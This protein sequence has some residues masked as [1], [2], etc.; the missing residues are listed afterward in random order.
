MVGKTYGV[1][2]VGI[3]SVARTHALAINELSN[4]KLIGG[5]CRTEQ[6]GRDFAREFGG[7]YI[8][9]YKDL[10]SRDDVDVVSIC[11][12]SGVHAEQAIAAAQAGKHI[13]CEKPL[14]ISLERVD[15]MIAAA[16]AAGIKL[17]GIFPFRFHLFP[18]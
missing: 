8:P 6:K 12:P 13:I 16:E 2:I 17:G 14:D 10:L 11:T 18:K 3:G 9:D 1:G 15:S 7:E 5:T 4:A